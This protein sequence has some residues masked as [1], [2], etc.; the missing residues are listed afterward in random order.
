MEKHTEHNVM[1]EGG[2]NIVWRDT[3]LN[4]YFGNNISSN[5]LVSNPDPP[6]V[7]GRVW[8]VRDADRPT[9]VLLYLST[10]AL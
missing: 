10:M 9:T 4:G 6:H 7:T 8:R 3:L 2:Q 5:N 1:K